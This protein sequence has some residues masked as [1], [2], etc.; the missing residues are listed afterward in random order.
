ML[1][2]SSVRKNKVNL[3]DYPY[4]QDVECRLLMSD[5]STIDVKLLEEILYS[6]LKI[7]L[8]KLARNLEC[9]EKIL[10]LPLKKFEEVGLLT[11]AEDAILIDKEKRKY[12]AFEITR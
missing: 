3:S 4:A 12:F 8:K 9:D 2:V 11:F 1:E 10:D 7:S 6:P 5:F